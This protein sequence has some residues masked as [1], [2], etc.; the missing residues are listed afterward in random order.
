MDNSDLE[1]TIFKEYKLFVDKSDQ[2]YPFKTFVSFASFCCYQFA[3][4]LLSFCDPVLLLSFLVFVSVILKFTRGECLSGN[5]LNITQHSVFRHLYI[6]FWS[7]LQLIF[8]ALPCVLW[9]RSQLLSLPDKPDGYSPL[10]T[11]SL[12]A[13]IHDTRH[14]ELLVVIM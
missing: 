10:T 3:F 1:I 11:N 9:L 2:R 13:V 4:C 7:F 12:I 14:Q 6:K 8:E 5:S